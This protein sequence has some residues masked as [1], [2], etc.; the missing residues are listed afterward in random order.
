MRL[1][2]PA[3]EDRVELLFPGA[4]L[5]VAHPLPIYAGTADTRAVCTVSVLEYRPE[6]IELLIHGAG[7]QVSVRQGLVQIQGGMSTAIEIAIS[8]GL[9]HLSSG[10]SH[11]VTL[12]KGPSGRRAWEQ[13]MMPNPETGAIVI[14]AT[15]AS[16]RLIVEPAPG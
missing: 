9:Y 4:G 2:N 13:E 15:F 12:Q 1:G 6:R 11:R 8:D 10:S 3:E 14:Q 7:A 16:A 5:A